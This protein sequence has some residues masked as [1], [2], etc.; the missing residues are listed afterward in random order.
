MEVG[1]NQG[2]A[3]VEIFSGENWENVHFKKDWGGNDRFFYANY[4]KTT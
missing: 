3:V 2:D 1:F 4:R